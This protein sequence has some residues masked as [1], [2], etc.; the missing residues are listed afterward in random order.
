MSHA[1]TQNRRIIHLHQTFHGWATNQSQAMFMNM[2]SIQLKIIIK[3][4]NFATQYSK[5]N[6]TGQLPGE[7]MGEIA[8]GCG[9]NSNIEIDRIFVGRIVSGC[10]EYVQPQN[11]LT[12]VHQTDCS[13]RVA[14]QIE[15]QN[16]LLGHKRQ[17]GSYLWFVCNAN[18]LGKRV[19]ILKSTQLKELTC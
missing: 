10:G 5:T 2:Q 19:V 6:A 11:G 13:D 12:T 9:R 15:H 4:L 8:K 18:V 7:N 17:I 3:L 1:Y 16:F 14:C